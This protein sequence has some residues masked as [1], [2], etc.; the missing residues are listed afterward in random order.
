MCLLKDE[1][2]IQTSLEGRPRECVGS[3]PDALV[4]AAEDDID[5]AAPG[6]KPALRSERKEKSAR[7]G[8]WC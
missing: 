8:T 7:N 2:H 6:K 4:V 5:G 1:P 3:R